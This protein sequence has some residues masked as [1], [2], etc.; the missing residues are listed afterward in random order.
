MEVIFQTF[1]VQKSSENNQETSTISVLESKSPVKKRQR[2]RITKKR[3]ETEAESLHSAL[4]SSSAPLIQTE[5]QPLQPKKTNLPKAAAPEVQAELDST[6]ENKEPQIEDQNAN[7]TNAVNLVKKKSGFD[8]GLVP[9]EI[10]GATNIGGF[11][12]LLKW[13]GVPT[14][15]FVD[16]ETA[17][18]KIPLLV[19]KFY[20]AR[21]HFDHKDVPLNSP[22]H[23]LATGDGNL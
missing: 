15:E 22:F 2:I 13:K 1:F 16:N 5:K 17:K 19:I 14:M 12:F 3:A 10:V 8:Q 9:D 6:K 23:P 20:E 18:K 11:K 7:Q 4:P 21:I